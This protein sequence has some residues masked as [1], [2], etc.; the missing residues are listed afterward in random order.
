[1]DYIKE[2]C[3]I[4]TIDENHFEA[5]VKIN[6]KFQYN[7]NVQIAPDKI[8][9]TSKDTVFKNFEVCWSFYDIGTQKTLVK[10]NFHCTL[11]NPVLNNIFN[12]TV[13][14]KLQYTIAQFEK[15]L[16]QQ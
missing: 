9:I 3:V 16:T 8:L 4:K 11:K 10:Y 15:F 12:L 13:K 2:C 6:Q 7:C 5:Q 1:M 14:K